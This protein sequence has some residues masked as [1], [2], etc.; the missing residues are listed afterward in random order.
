MK[1]TSFSPQ[2]L[3]LIELSEGFRAK[4]YICPAGKPTIGFG[5]TFYENGTKVTMKDKSIT[6]LRA[7]DLALWHL[8]PIA[9]QVD[10]YTPDNIT[11]GMFDA[12]GDFI[13]NVGIGNFKTSTLCKKINANPF[14]PTIGTSFMAWIFGGDGT[15]NGI[16][17]DG[18]GLID[19]AGEKQRLKGLVTRNEARVKMYFS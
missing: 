1:I 16:D 19:E 7:I 4:P 6:R 2:V 9:L 13:Y 15:H 3:S 10:S 8:K 5:S 17:D 11:Q 12:I 14:D 18:D